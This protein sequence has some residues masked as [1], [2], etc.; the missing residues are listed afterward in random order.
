MSTNHKG[1]IAYGTEGFGW[2]AADNSVV[3]MDAQTT[4]AFGQ[5]AATNE[6]AHIYAAYA[7][8]ALG[9]PDLIYGDAYWP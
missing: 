2:I 9:N 5:A 1:I 6:S 7:L 8:K 4:F 3:P